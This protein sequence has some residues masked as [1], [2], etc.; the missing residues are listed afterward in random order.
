MEVTSPTWNSKESYYIFSFYGA[1][2]TFQ[3]THP[4][5][6]GE[7]YNYSE[8]KLPDIPSTLLESVLLTFLDKTNKW[9]Q[10]PLRLDTM[11]KRLRHVLDST[12][13]VK[14]ESVNAWF[15]S[16][17][18]PAWITVKSKEFVLGRQISDWTLTEAQIP[19]NFLGAPTPRAQS[20]EQP[21]AEQTEE[22]RRIIHIQNTLDTLIP[23][24]DLPLSD[25]PPLAFPTSEELNPNKAESRRRIREARL[26]FALAKLKSQRME[27]KYYERYGEKPDDSEESSDLSS[28]SEEFLE[29]S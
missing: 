14:P 7:D 27:Q 4:E 19:D 9:F 20:P 22:E 29:D 6:I 28:D 1:K 23:V 11:K 2:P 12:V 18:V 24:G 16:R 3:V 25:L 17:W 10:T 15:H 13:H 5:F 8:T 26:R 21:L